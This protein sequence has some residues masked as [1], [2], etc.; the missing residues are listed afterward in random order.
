MRGQLGSTWLTVFVNIQVSD[1]CGGKAIGIEQSGYSG[2]VMRQ[3]DKSTQ[4]KLRDQNS[5][6][7]TWPNGIA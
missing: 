6:I 4:W 5:S 1:T 2:N 7:P 3:I